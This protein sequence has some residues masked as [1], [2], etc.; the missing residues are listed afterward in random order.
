MIVFIDDILI[1][2]KNDEEHTFHLTI[3]LQTLKERQFYAKFSKCEFY[4]NEVVFLG[5]VISGNRIFIDSRK[6]EAIVNWEHSK[7]V[8]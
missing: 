3:V 7:N 5:H 2:S 8:I 4:L 6:V 1:Y